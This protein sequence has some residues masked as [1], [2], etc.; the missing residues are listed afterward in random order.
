MEIKNTNKPQDNELDALKKA[1]IKKGLI[2]EN[3]IK[4]EKIK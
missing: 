3:E 4:A 2:T 1:L